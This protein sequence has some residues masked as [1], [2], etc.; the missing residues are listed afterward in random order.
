M[1]PRSNGCGNTRCDS[2]TAVRERSPSI[3]SMGMPEGTT[4]GG[5]GGGVGSRGGRLRGPGRHRHGRRGVGLRHAERGETRGGQRRVRCR[6]RGHPAKL[7][8][9]RHRARSRWCRRSR[10]SRRR[11]SGSGQA[12]PAAAQAR[13][14]A[15]W[16]S[17][18]PT[19]SAGPPSASGRPA[20]AGRSAEGPAP[21][22]PPT[23]GTRS[24]AFI[25]G[26]RAVTGAAADGG[27]GSG[28]GAP[29]AGRGGPRAVFGCEAWTSELYVRIEPSSV[30][31]GDAGMPLSL[32]MSMRLRDLGRPAQVRL[33]LLDAIAEDRAPCTPRPRRSR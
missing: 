19:A 23:P 12:A 7:L 28:A 3:G 16:R 14:A 30:C 17:C 26:G 21:V 27:P 1:L 29:A 31:Q 33:A 32:S 20:A 10:R 4:T 11:S 18:A 5:N 25:C 24:V 6:R 8:H 13:A 22:V 15:E 2:A 9:L